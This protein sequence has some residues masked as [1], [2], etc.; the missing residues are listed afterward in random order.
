LKPGFPI[1]EFHHLLR[2]DLGKLS[3]ESSDEPDGFS[4]DILEM[5]SDEES[6]SSAPQGD[7]L[8][9][10]GLEATFSWV[11]RAILG[12]P[13]MFEKGEEAHLTD[14]VVITK[15][16][17]DHKKYHIVV[18]EADER[19]CLVAMRRPK[20]LF[21]HNYLF[22][23]IGLRFPPTKFE[24]AVINHFQLAPSQLHPNAWGFIRSYEIVC[25]RYGVEPSLKVFFYLMT[26][27]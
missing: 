6:I 23:T 24:M 4:A 26:L 1:K 9:L 11:D 17:K 7:L 18:P 19:P 2:D 13:S 22:T 14:V 25:C 5:S 8:I 10:S 21:M 3:W 27:F 16:E 12:L 20:F 15:S